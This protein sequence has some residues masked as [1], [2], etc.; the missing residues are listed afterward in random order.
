MNP[1]QR[2][3][4]VIFDFI[5]G[6]M[7]ILQRKFFEQHVR[8]CSHCQKVLNQARLV[9]S[10]IQNLSK[11]RTSENFHILLRERIRRQM[12]G[13]RE[14]FSLTTGFSLKWIPAAALFVIMIISGFWIIDQK[15]SILHHSFI[16]EVKESPTSIRN[17]QFNGQ[18]DYIEDDYP[19][20]SSLSVSR[21]DVPPVR[22][23][24]DTVS[25]PQSSESVQAF[26][27]PVDF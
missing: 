3:S 19:T 18:I 5:D 11:I 21:N 16:A 17:F 14:I 2:F 25:V 26:L 22:A 8:D 4:R 24:M 1:C 20:S 6:E 12:A 9:R 27:T 15:T 23:S 10:H 13:K 7:D